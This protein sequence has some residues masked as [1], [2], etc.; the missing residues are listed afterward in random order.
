[1]RPFKQY[2][3]DALNFPLYPI[4]VQGLFPGVAGGVSAAPSMQDQNSLADALKAQEQ[5]I[6]A[7]KR[8]VS[9]R[10]CRPC[11]DIDRDAGAGLPHQVV[12][13]V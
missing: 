11:C 5:L 10:R 8:Q 6:S 7:Y 9:Q 12:T 1:M 4:P 3:K 13:T 2:P